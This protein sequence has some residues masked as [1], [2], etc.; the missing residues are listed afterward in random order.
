MA[1]APAATT[2]STIYICA[3]RLAQRH[4]LAKVAAVPNGALAGPGRPEN[5]A[6]SLAVT[7]SLSWDQQ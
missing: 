4:F 3:H 5:L 7:L 1:L 2:R 6:N